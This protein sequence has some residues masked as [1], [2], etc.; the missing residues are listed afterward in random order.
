MPAATLSTDVRIRIAYEA[1]QKVRSRTRYEVRQWANWSRGD[2]S[3]VNYVYVVLLEFP[4]FED[5]FGLYVGKSH[6]PPRTRLRNHRSGELANADVQKY[7][8]RLLQ[9]VYQHLNPMLPRE[10]PSIERKLWRALVDADIGWVSMGGLRT[11]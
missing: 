5:P 10:A 6:Y 1:A 4:Q 7:G 8:V 2:T 11:R 3:Y 9:W